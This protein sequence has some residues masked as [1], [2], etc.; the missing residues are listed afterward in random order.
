MLTIAFNILIAAAAAV[1][2]L[3]YFGVKPKMVALK[4]QSLKLG[5]MLG[6][7]AASL[8]MSSYSAYRYHHPRV[9]VVKK[10]VAEPYPYRWLGDKPVSLH[11]VGK[12]FENREVLLDN[13]EYTYCVFKNV[14]FVYNGTAPFQLFGDSVYGGVHFRS[15]NPSVFPTLALMYSLHL[16]K[17]D[18]NL[19]SPGVRQLWK[20]QVS[21][22]AIVHT[23]PKAK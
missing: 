19:L 6:L 13:T 15:D 22:A 16:I 7:V 12:H 23:E 10:Y 5:I 2:I 20:R 9:R 8:L 3:D 14:T 4:R 21:R 11:V 1:A 17:L 18:V